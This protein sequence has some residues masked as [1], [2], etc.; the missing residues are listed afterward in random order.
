MQK[1]WSCIY[2]KYLRNNFK[3]ISQPPNG[4]K[5]LKTSVNKKLSEKK[6]PQPC[7]SFSELIG[8]THLPGVGLMDG[9]ETEKMRWT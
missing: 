2:N 8:P 6:C 5:Q 4:G 1:E 3:G 7:F 9:D